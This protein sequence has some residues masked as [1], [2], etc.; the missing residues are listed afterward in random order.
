M[1]AEKQL[2]DRKV[3]QEVR[4]SENILTDLVEKSNA[5]FKN[6]RR[7][8]VISERELKYFTFEYKKATNLGKLYLL[9][10][11]RKCLKNIPGRPVISNCGTLTEKVSEFLDH[12][13][14]TVYQNGWSYIKDSGD[15]LKK[16]RDVGNI[17]E[18]AIL[19][20]ADVVGLYPNIPHNAGLK[21]LT[22]MCE[23]REHKAVSTDDLVKMA[24]FVLENNYFEFNGDVKKQISGTAIST[25][26]ALA[27][28]FIFTDELETKFLQ[29]QSLQPLVWFRYIKD[30]F[31]I[32]TY[33]KDKLEKF[34]DDLNR[35]NNNIKFTH[36]S[37]K[38]NV[39]FLDLIVKLSKGRLTTDLH[40]KDAD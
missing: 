3:Y 12:H 28:V 40:I 22:N 4:F 31:F 30:I 38:K 11:I 33:G 8:G 26:F 17:P 21:A 32:W 6:L 7:K 23:A 24:R 14:K 19:V 37:S 29:S 27:Y 9:P 5:M 25:K 2:K 15:F 16:I 36:E 18:N 10:K 39:T 35:F 13:L 1:E 20:T 34:L